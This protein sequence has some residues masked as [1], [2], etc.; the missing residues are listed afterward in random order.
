M[1]PYVIRYGSKSSTGEMVVKIGKII[2][3]GVAGLMIAAVPVS[4][5]FAATRPGAA[6]PTAGSSAV[7]AQ[8]DDNGKFIDAWPAIAIVI[9]AILL[10]IWLASKGDGGKDGN[11]SRG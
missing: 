3:N 2:R 11:F 6:V 4:S 9:A 10:A 8:Y 5:S 7:S 1:R